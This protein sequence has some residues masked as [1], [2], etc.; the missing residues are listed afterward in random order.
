MWNLKNNDK[1]K[2]IYKTDLEIEFIASRGEGWE[3]R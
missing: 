2:I 1:I 3:E